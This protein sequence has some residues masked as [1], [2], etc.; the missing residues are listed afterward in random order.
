MGRFERHG[1]DLA[2][3]AL[4]AATAATVVGSSQ[5]AFA[6]LALPEIDVGVSQPTTA[7]AANGAATQGAAGAQLPISSPD[8]IGSKAPPGSAPALAPSQAPLDSFEPTSVVSDKILRDVVITSG[9]Y[10]DAVKY[11]PGFVSN[12][13]NGPLGDAKGGWRGFQDGQYNITFDGIPFGDEN[14]P[15]HHSAAYFPAQFLGK[16]TLNR[17]PG[18]AS[19]VGYA[20]FGGTLAL[21][22]LEL[23]DKFGGSVESSYGSFST[24]VTAV[25]LQSGLDPDTGVRALA[26]YYHAETAGAL[27]YNAVESN[28]W[29]LK[30]DRRFGD[31]EVTGFATYGREHYDGG[32]TPSV[33]QYF[34]GGPTYAALGPNPFTAQYVGYNNS[35]KQ[36]D[37]E[38]VNL[39]T[40]YWG[41]HFNDKVYTYSYW[42]PWLQNNP[43]NTATEGVSTLIG[44]GDTITKVKVP[45]IT[46]GTITQVFKVPVGDITGYLK[47]NDYRAWGNIFDATYDL[48]GGYASGVLRTGVWWERGD[49]WRLQEYINYTTG[50]TYPAYAATLLGAY[51]GA[52]KLDLGS[53][54]ENVQPFLEYEWK[55]FENLSITPGYKFEAFTRNQTARI[56]QTT[57]S[58]QYYEQTFRA[59]LP[60]LSVHYLLTPQFAVYG[61]ASRGFLVPTVSAYYTFFPQLDNIQPETT[62]NYQLGAIYKSGDFAGDIDVYQI[63]G[64]NFPIN[65]TNT[66]GL[67]TYQNGGA[68]RYRGL[69]AEGTY[70]IIQGLA[71]YASGALSDARF[72]QG[73]NWGLEIGGAP[74]YVVS[75]GFI[76]DDG[77]FFGS[78]LQKV[79]GPQYGST[80]NESYW[81]GTPGNIALG[82]GI[83]LTNP[84]NNHIPTYATTDLVIG[85]RTD[86]F[87]QYGIKNKVEVKFGITNL[88]DNHGLTDIG[89]S[90]VGYLNP[91]VSTSGGVIAPS[92]GS[93]LTYTSQ[94]GRYVYGG[95]KVSF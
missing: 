1:V 62:T 76:Y 88:F 45:L 12:N 64:N 3:I 78:I 57:I 29:L 10:N 18:D 85:A 35:E 79:T 25:T 49:N 20:T 9:D 61:Q 83:Q 32:N 42:Y 91:S 82:S 81:Y 37:M 46:G 28:Q 33:Q 75:G 7:P 94:A 43:A 31:V 23:K 65:Y 47:D 84:Q 66:S 26:Q 2:V 17:G 58:P 89:G 72:L 38:Y 70:K 6:Q 59:G 48:R 40:D 71:A 8:A 30:A 80:G 5:K 74:R 21:Q 22:S 34:L 51:Q 73:P 63:T 95:V 15:T 55:P 41:V 90:P 13:P 77:A 56:N 69:E 52:Y 68:F 4:A 24:F 39:K 27:Q 54:T 53:H 14:D 11:T 87:S 86:Y 60:F 93:P 16:V 44:G 50:V 92:A 67:T 36:T 19:Q